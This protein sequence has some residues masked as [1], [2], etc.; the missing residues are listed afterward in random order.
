MVG[1]AMNIHKMQHM[2]KGYSSQLVCVYMCEHVCVCMCVYVCACVGVCVLS[3]ASL[4]AI[5][6]I[7]TG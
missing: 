6:S 5:V 3:F 4:A 2:H 7:F 1:Y